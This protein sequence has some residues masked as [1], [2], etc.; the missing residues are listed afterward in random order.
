MRRH[1]LGL[2]LLPGL[3]LAGCSADPLNII[4]LNARAPGDKCD[5]EDASLYTIAPHLQPEG[6]RSWPSS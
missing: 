4:V 3:L 1:I 2:F 6:E 5:F